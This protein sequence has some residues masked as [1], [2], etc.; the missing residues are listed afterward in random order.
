MSVAKSIV[1]DRGA[2][3]RPPIFDEKTGKSRKKPLI[4]PRDNV[5]VRGLRDLWRKPSAGLQDKIDKA[6]RWL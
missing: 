4:A 2:F 5:G 6:L 1:N 3:C